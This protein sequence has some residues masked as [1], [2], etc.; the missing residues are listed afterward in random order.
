MSFSGEL[1]R[2]NVFKVGAAYVGSL[3]TNPASRHRLLWRYL[4]C[5]D[6]DVRYLGAGAGVSRGRSSSLGVRTNT[7]RHKEDPAV[8]DLDRALAIASNFAF[9][10][11]QKALRLA[12]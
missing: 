6:S 2:R 3:A 9:A 8:P 1:G 4:A 11:G 7:G 10:L 12:A 5:L